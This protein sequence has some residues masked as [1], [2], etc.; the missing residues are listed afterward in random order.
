M[1]YWP[2]S[3]QV[4]TMKY[5]MMDWFFPMRYLIGE[6]LQN[7]VLPVWNPFINLGYPLHADPQS[8]GLYPVVWFIGYFF[9]YN[10]YTINFEY[11][12]HILFAFYGMKKLSEVIGLSNEVAIL[13]GV[14]YACCGFFIGNAQH[15]TWIISAAWIPYILY[16]YKKLVEENS[17]INAIGCALFSFLLLTGGYPAFAIIIFY[18]LLIAFFIHFFSLLRK[19]DLQSLKQ[20]V[21]RNVLFFFAFLIQSLVFLVFFLEVLPFMVRVETLSLEKAQLLPFSLK[22]LYPFCC[23]LQLAEMLNFTRRIFQCQTDISA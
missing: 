18:V 15:L 12:L 4:Y 3:S 1:V 21:I 13:V 9:G 7:G 6:C 17:W 23:L 16:F 14:S 10:P 8:G 22:V 19:R 20:F 2:I 11:I 5:D